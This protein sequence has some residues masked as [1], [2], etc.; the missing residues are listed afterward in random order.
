[1]PHPTINTKRLTLSA[2]RAADIPTIVEY[3]KAKEIAKNMLFLEHEYGEAEAVWWV[4]FANESFKNK[5]QYVFRI[6]LK[7]N[8]D[9]IGGIAIMMKKFKAAEVGYWVGKPHW[10]KGYCSEGMGAILKYGFEELGL[11]R[12]FAVHYLSNMGSG[13]VMIKNGMI[14]EGEF[15]DFAVIDGQYV[16]AAQYRLTKEEYEKMNNITYYS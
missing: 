4:N 14:K 6:G 16:D 11:Q 12:M 7:P 1:M 8:D 2:P 13:K 15:K 3:G 9:F 10:G 5:S